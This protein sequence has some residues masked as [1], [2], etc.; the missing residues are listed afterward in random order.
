MEDKC[1]FNVESER[2]NQLDEARF[3]K[4]ETNSTKS[5]LLNYSSEGDYF[6]ISGDYVEQPTGK[7]TLSLVST[8][9]L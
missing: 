2:L 5:L 1:K 3:K 4:N 9:K 6:R 8:R 7:K